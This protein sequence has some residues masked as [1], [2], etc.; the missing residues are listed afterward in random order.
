MMFDVDTLIQAAD[1]ESILIELGIQPV[2][3][4]N[5]NGYELYFYCFNPEHD[6]TKRKMSIAE[7][8]KYK[9]LFYCWS[10]SLRGNIIQIIRHFTGKSFN[11]ALQW[12]Q[13]RTGV[14]ELLG[15]E[16][17]IY[18]VKKQKLNYGQEDLDVELSTYDLPS[19]YV[20]C[21]SGHPVTRPAE[22]FL[23]ERNIGRQT[24]LKFEV[25]VSDHPKIGYCITIPIKFKGNIHSI[26]FA[27]PVSGGLKRYP[28]GSPQG[29]ILFNYD[30]CVERDKY[31]LVE[32]ILDVLM[33]DT[34]G[35]GPG[36]ACFTNMVSDAQVDLLK[37]FK[38]H[39]VF[40][41]RDSPRGW[42]L[43]A[44]LV[45]SLDKSVKLILPPDGKDPGDC[46][47]WEVVDS[48]AQAK[49]YAD[50]EVNAYMVERAR[51][52]PNVARLHKK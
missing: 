28:V 23:S 18:N 9:G 21:Y 52:T 20:K 44:R 40:P 43:V 15:I 22:D 14:G 38:N 6:D 12:M 31:V 47:P 36:M 50:W 33:L 7:A 19:S 37:S 34:M 42:D 48:F 10:C 45:S 27:Q 11:D 26:F 2:R 51:D 41:D 3:R 49:S 13:E 30:E 4:Q 29:H 39:C 5:K 16:S 35:L 1:I 32:S 46:D 17:L 24:A 25:G 8:G